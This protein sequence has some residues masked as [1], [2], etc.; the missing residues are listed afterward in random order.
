LAINTKTPKVK[1]TI[2]IPRPID[3]DGLNAGNIYELRM[4]LTLKI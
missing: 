2:T 4:V 3:D 1:I